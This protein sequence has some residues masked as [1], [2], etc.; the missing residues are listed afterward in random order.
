MDIDTTPLSIAIQTA[1]RAEVAPAQREDA[2][3]A[4]CSTFSLREDSRL[5]LVD[6]QDQLLCRAFDIVFDR[7]SVTKGKVMRQLLVLLVDRTAQCN[8]NS[9]QKAL[10]NVLRKAFTIL[11]CRSQQTKVKAAL[12]VLSLLLNKNVIGPDRLAACYFDFNS[13]S[14]VIEGN[15][16]RLDDKFQVL[17][18]IILSWT[19]N[20]DATHAVGNMVEL[21]V[22]R[23]KVQQSKVDSRNTL[24]SI[25]IWANAL[26]ESI[27]SH[28]GD[29]HDYRSYIFPALFKVDASDYLAFLQNLGLDRLLSNSHNNKRTELIERD[30]L[31]N[32]LL[33]VSLQVGKEIGLIVESG[34]FPWLLAH[35][36][37]SLSKPLLQT[38]PIL[39][40]SILMEAL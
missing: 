26:T 11:D 15:S 3:K 21:L 19:R 9:K 31:M 35:I 34:E 17:L 36:G 1:H 8:P 10:Y 32:D 25:P 4:I 39:G 16:V 6:A 12:Q 24:E 7:S 33:Y 2:I 38:P 5:P 18:N 22:R 23:W 13:P 29:L 40:A 37:Q 27:S 20:R 14:A 30:E 28:P